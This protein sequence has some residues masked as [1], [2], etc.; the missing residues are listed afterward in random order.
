LDHF[1]FGG[2]N[3]RGWP[4]KMSDDELK[5]MRNAGVVLQSQREITVSINIQVAKFVFST[6]LSPP[7]FVEI[8]ILYISSFK[9]HSLLQNSD[10][11]VTCMATSRKGLTN[12][13][14]TFGLDLP[15][16]MPIP[17]LRKIV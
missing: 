10:S 17:V 7:L 5:I 2:A 8:P 9:P 11:Q 1:Y 6:S 3:M 4:E 13:H 14:S 12:D 15:F 16:K